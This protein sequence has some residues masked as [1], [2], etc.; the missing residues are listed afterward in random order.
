MDADERER[1]A[2]LEGL[3]PEES[4]TILQRCQIARVKKGEKIFRAGESADSL[5][6]VRSGQIELRFPVVYYSGTVEIPLDMIRAGEV[7][8][9]SAL[10]PPHSYTLMGCAT[11]DSELLQ[12]KRT[13]LQDA[14]E[15]SP[16]LGYLVMKNVA[17]I[18][19]ERYELTRRMLIAGIETDLKKKE[20]KQLWQSA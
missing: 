3:T 9:W 14:C 12:F 16:R 2:F 13:D 18:I 8:G 1:F 4:H 20:N 10:I 6:L 19:G 7:C 5:Y 17:R 11:E 15:S